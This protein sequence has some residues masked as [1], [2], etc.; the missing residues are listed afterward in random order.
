ML[1]YLLN[2][3][4]MVLLPL[5]KTKSAA[6]DFLKA[7]FQFYKI[8]PSSKFSRSSEMFWGSKGLFKEI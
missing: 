3:N 2:R 8:L 7:N 6:Y 4:E 1:L 5:F